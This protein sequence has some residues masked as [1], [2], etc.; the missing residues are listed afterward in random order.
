MQGVFCHLPA[1]SE[2]DMPQ[3]TIKLNTYDPAIVGV[4]ERLRKNRKQ[5]AFTHEAL[6]YFLAS[7]MGVQVIDLMCRDNASSLQPAHKANPAEQ[8]HDSV[9][10]AQ[11]NFP[12]YT[13]NLANDSCGD[14]MEKILK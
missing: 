1:E 9:P 6:K 3:Y 8:L 11:N 12:S 13:S 7:E 5:A 4:F 14:V 2:L 10:K